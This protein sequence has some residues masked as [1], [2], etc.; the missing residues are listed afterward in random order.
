MLML[1]ASVFFKLG[2]CGQMQFT[3][4]A[5][6]QLDDPENQHGK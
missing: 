2:C 1:L 4:L 5:G 6:P 3:K